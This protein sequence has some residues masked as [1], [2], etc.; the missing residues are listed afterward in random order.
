[1]SPH[2]GD[3]SGMEAVARDFYDRHQAMLKKENDLWQIW[4]FPLL[5]KDMQVIEMPEGAKV[6]TVQ[7]QD[8]G[9]PGIRSIEGPL[10]VWAE[11]KIDR[12]KVQR[13]FWVKGT[14]E[15][16]GPVRYR[17]YVGTVQTPTGFV[18]HVYDEEER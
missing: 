16:L 15:V 11:V 6:L 13:K 12:P 8:R 3:D 4:K 1:M 18:W 7:Y 14:G 10:M 5:V 17:H 9:W 2:E